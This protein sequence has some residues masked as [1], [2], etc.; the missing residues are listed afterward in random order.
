MLAHPLPTDCVVQFP[1]TVPSIRWDAL[2][3]PAVASPSS[4]YQGHLGS[5][6]GVQRHSADADFAHYGLVL[7]AHSRSDGR[8]LWVATRYGRP[9]ISGRCYAAVRAAGLGLIVEA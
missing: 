8:L 4:T 2:Q 5:C 6:A 7:V 1:D 9:I 3:A